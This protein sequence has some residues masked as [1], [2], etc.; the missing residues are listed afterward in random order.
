MSVSAVLTEAIPF[1]SSP[2][3][4]IF[5]FI[6]ILKVYFFCLLRETS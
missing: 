6:T 1:K 4:N 5:N 3:N 2:Y